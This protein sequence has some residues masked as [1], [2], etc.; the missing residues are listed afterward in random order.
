MEQSILKLSDRLQNITRF[1]LDTAPVIYYVEEND[2]YLP[3]IQMVFDHLDAG[4][5]TA[6]TSPITLAECLVMPY[7]LKNADL[8][9]AFTEL[10]TSGSG[11]E[12][13]LLDHEQADRAAELRARYNLSLTDAF[14]VAIALTTNCDA[15]LTNDITLKRVTEIDVIV[16][17][18][19]EAG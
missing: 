4:L 18:E 10:I 15:F 5:L 16:L 8:R 14:Q 7:R 13:T 6:V 2:R 17:D 9:Q 3:L 19:T 12:F 11:A 1:F